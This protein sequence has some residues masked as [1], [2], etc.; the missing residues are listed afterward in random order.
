MAIAS[1]GN[2]PMSRQDWE[3]LQARLPEVDRVSYE[4]YLK[5]FGLSTGPVGTGVVLGTETVRTRFGL[6]EALLNSQW[7]NGKGVKGTPGY[8]PG[9][10]DVFDLWKAGD[11][12]GAE[13]A[14]FKT[15]WSKLDADVQ[16]R[17]LLQ[18][19]NSDLYKERLRSWLLGIKPK[20]M[21]QGLQ[22]DD[23]TL[24]NYYKNGID[25][26]TI[27]DELSSGVKAGTAQGATA[28]A[29]AQLRT[30]A[31]A[32]GFNFDKDFALQADSWLQQIAKG[33]P[34]DDFARL[35]RAQAKLGLPEKVGA[36]LDQGL[37]LANVYAPYRNAMASLLELSPD[38]INLDDPLLRSA[39][40]PDKEMSVYDFKRAIRKDSRWQ[41]TDN[42]REEVSNIALN[43]LRDFGFQ[44]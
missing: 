10:Q 4:D 19:E 31:R 1:I 3:K 13:D 11:I 6:G 18:L 9:L 22:V 37:D 12:A 27:F 14:Y 20:L 30:I 2:Q 33:K 7:A 44:G 42:A 26:L 38:S 17:T 41:Y 29:L 25:D 43:V 35:I 8:I 36:L 24:E 28:D 21:A 5:T 16:E 15:D 40:G 23:A 34:I 39:Y 32:N